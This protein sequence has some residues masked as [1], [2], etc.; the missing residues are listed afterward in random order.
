M[1]AKFP[2]VAIVGSGPSGCYVAQFLQKKW[3]AA[4]IAIFEALPVPYGLVRYGVAAD[5]QGSKAVI[6]QFERMFEKGGVVFQ[7]NVSVGRDIS[8]AKLAA[9]FDVVVLATGLNNDA[10]LDIPVDPVAPVMGAGVLLKALN[11][12]PRIELPKKADGVVR[13]LGRDIAV[14]GSG[15]VAIDVLRMIAK[16]DPELVGSDISD[17]TRA[18]LGTSKVRSIT[19]VSRS[20]AAQAKCDESMMVELLSLPG[21]GI[22]VEGLRDNE[23]GRIPEL[24]L[25]ASKSASSDTQ[26][27]LSINFLFNA[28]PLEIEKSAGGAQLTVTDKLFE[29]SE[30]L[31]FD[32]IVTAI[33]FSNG[34]AIESTI[35]PSSLSGESIYTV[36][37]LKRGPSGTVAENRKDAKSVADNIISDFDSGVLRAGKL[38]L[39]SV[40]H[41]LSSGTVTHADWRRIDEYEVMSAGPGRC[42]KKIEKVRDM[43]RVARGGDV[44][45]RSVIEQKNHIEELV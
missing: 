44:S 25:A 1:S 45:L 12:H 35:P 40:A 21:V 27:R 29:N 34:S 26:T 36:G 17:G 19:L 41:E 8:F 9:S 4:Q 30:K 13:E 39:V 15:N 14:I 24:L 31:E 3:S 43:L 16:S 2:T 10:V 42:R 32:T 7:G 20:G 22:T 23:E 5:H 18:D 37:W 33:G 38:G 28:A 11:G 6:Q